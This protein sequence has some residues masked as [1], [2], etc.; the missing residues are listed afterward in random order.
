[1]RLSVPYPYL[2]GEI[3]DCVSWTKKWLDRLEEDENDEEAKQNLW[4]A[5]EVLVNQIQTTST[6]ESSRG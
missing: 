4:G 3:K 5:I 1:M 2:V 6:Y